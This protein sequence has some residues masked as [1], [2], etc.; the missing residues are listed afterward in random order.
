MADHSST[1]VAGGMKKPVGCRADGF[2]NE[3]CG[4][5]ITHLKGNG[6]A[7]AAE[8]HEIHRH[9]RPVTFSERQ[10]HLALTPTTT[11]D[12]VT[13]RFTKLG[14]QFRSRLTHLSQVRPPGPRVVETSEDEKHRGHLGP[15]P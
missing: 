13:F 14:D 3:R 15:N 4:R 1:G 12:R 2:G 11:D 8:D 5:M 7:A 6:E 9:C 10:V